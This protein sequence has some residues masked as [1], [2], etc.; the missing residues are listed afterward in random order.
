MDDDDSG[1]GGSWGSL[2]APNPGGNY[3]LGDPLGGTTP[4]GGYPGVQVPGGNANWGND[5]GTT[6]GGGSGKPTL[7]ANQQTALLGDWYDSGIGDSASLSSLYGS[8]VAPNVK[9]INNIQSQLNTTELDPLNAFPDSA[10]DRAKHLIRLAKEAQKNG[11]NLSDIIGREP[12]PTELASLDKA[13]FGSLYGVNPNNLQGQTVSQMLAAQRVGDILGKVGGVL[14][15]AAM[16]APLS[17]ALGAYNAYKGAQSGDSLGSI[18]GK[19]LSGLGGWSSVVGQGLQGNYGNSVTGALTKGHLAS[20]LSALFAGTGVD[21][22]Q[23]KDVSKNLGGIAGYTLGTAKG[24][25]YG[26]LGQSLGRTYLSSL[27]RK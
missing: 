12:T 11:T 23:G 14:M 19:A 3:K 22:Y 2:T 16:P 10:E 21:A 20:P 5:G 27:F 18:V 7:T 13:G 9:A 15:S 17:A 4:G 1:G 26:G 8:V 25:Y 6:T 24:N